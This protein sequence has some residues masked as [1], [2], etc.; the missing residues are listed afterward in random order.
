MNIVLTRLA[1]A[2]FIN[3]IKVLRTYSGW[4][5]K[6]TKVACDALRD[7]FKPISFDLINSDNIPL[8]VIKREFESCG[9]T[10]VMPTETPLHEIVKMYPAYEVLRATAKACIDK[11]KFK[12]ATMICEL[13]D[14]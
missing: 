6:D 1:T 13:L 10:V 3:A 9:Y 8:D 7:T 11:E 5:L 4:G 2:K 14:K 12:M